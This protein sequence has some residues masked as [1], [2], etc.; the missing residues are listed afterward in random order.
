MDAALRF[1]HNAMN[2]VARQH[3]STATTCGRSAVVAHHLAK[4]R[5]AGSNPVVRSE[6]PR[7]ASDLQVQIPH[8]VDPAVWPSGLGKGL[9]SPVRGFDSRHRLGRLAQWESAS[10]TRKRSQVQSLYRPPRKAWSEPHLG[11]RTRPSWRFGADRVTSWVTNSPAARE[12]AVH[13]R[14]SFL[15]DRS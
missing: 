14:S 10:L 3:G 1:H 13:G 6:E 8:S 2:D 4:V 5:V 9:Q 12:D 11:I 15:D 7:V